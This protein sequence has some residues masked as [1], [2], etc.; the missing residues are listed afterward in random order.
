[1]KNYYEDKL[2]AFK[3]EGKL[4]NKIVLYDDNYKK[5]IKVRHP[6]MSMENIEDILK[7]P[8]Y[9]YKPSR[10]STIFYYEKLY[11][12][13]TYRVV[14]ESCKKHTKEVVTAYKVGN[15]EGYTV[16]HIYCVYD[17]ETFIEY[18]DMNKELEDD[19]DYFYGIFNKA[20]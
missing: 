12:R 19:F 20:E 11:E 4:H 1:M 9:V 16:K 10:N 7:T 17:K 5:H 8:D 6:E 18:E 3:I 14:I 13:D 2:L 15:E